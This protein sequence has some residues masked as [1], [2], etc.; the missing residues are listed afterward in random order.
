[1]ANIFVLVNTGG[2][3]DMVLQLGP[4][5]ESAAD[6]AIA[7][8]RI[9]QGEFD[10]QCK[11]RYD[12]ASH[13]FVEISTGK[14]RAVSQ[15]PYTAEAWSRFMG[16]M[17]GREYEA[18]WF[19]AEVRERGAQGAFGLKDFHLGIPLT[20]SHHDMVESAIVAINARG[21]EVNHINSHSV[22]RD[23]L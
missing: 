10:R 12:A 5:T 22:R 14:P 23:C 18:R 3:T 16:A 4:Y 2:E 17:E 6:R 13:Q 20:G 8:Q 15:S 19:Q 21:Y 9:G 11:C 7:W 1:M